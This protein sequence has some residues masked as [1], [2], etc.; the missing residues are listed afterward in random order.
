M[1]E[2]LNIVT[3]NW[4]NAEAIA[5]RIRTEVFIIEQAIPP[6][7]EWDEEDASAVHFIAYADAQQQTPIGCARLLADGHFGRL[8]VVKNKRR[9]GVAQALLTAIENYAI[10]HTDISQLLAGAQLSALN[11]Y[12]QQGFTIERE[13][14][15]DANIAHVKIYKA[16]HPKTTNS[17]RLPDI[18]SNVLQAQQD[19][20]P[21]Y[22]TSLLAIS[23]WLEIV[24]DAHP[25]EILLLTN[26]LQQPLWK[27]PILLDALRRHVLFSRHHHL[28]VIVKKDDSRF[29]EHPLVRLLDRLGDRAALD[30]HPAV[31]SNTILLGRHAWM[32]FESSSNGIITTASGSM[33][34]VLGCSALRNDHAEVINLAQPCRMTIQLMI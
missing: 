18:P 10:E 27:D 3:T 4:E 17:E 6:E 20:H 2:S 31:A 22:L 14:Y 21:Y 26:D 1:T 16:L 9:Q 23:G 29:S 32:I 25:R 30:Y 28:R 24:L 34:D 8:A 13:I 7:L 5:K 33:R 15:D 12:R 11:L 19:D